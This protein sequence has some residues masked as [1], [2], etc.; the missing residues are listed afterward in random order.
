MTTTLQ[1]PRSRA[2]PG[3]QD[4]GRGIVTFALYAPGKR[5]VHLVGSFNDW[6]A[7]ADAMEDRGGG[8]WVT[9]KQLPRGKCQYQFIL[10]DGLVICD[11][12]AQEIERLAGPDAPP[13]AVI[14]VS[15]PI[16]QWQHDGWQ[17]PQL[18]DLIIQ[19][20]HV[21]DF[22]PQGTL[23]GVHSRL[24]YLREMGI[25]AIEFMPLYECS[26]N[27]YWGYEPAYFL[28]LRR[29]FGMFE[30]LL[31][32]V[33]EAHARGIAVILDLVLAHTGR[34]HPFHAMY[35]YEQSPWY[36][37]SVGE[38]DQYGLPM[39]DFRK[40]ATNSFVR[41]VQSYWLNVFHFDG[42][43]YDYLAGIG[44][45]WQGRGLPYLMRTAR[46]IRPEAY[47]IGECIPERPDLVNNSGIGCVWH[48]RTKL[49]LEALL[50]EGKSNCGDWNDFAT[51]VRAFDPATQDYMDATFMVNYLECHDDP[52]AV[53]EIQEAGFDRSVAMRKSALAA[54]IL[55]TLPGEPMLYQGQE[56]GED[57]VKSLQINKIHWE[58][59]DDEDG[60]SL[61]EHYRRMCHLRRGRA[62]LRCQNFHY[63]LVDANRK[64]IVYHRRLGMADQVVVAAN[65][66][67]D[68]VK[69]A[70][71]FPD[72]GMWHEFFSRLVMDIDPPLDWTL[73][74]YSAVIFLS[75][76]S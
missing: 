26:T 9:H 30:D 35:P 42:F 73:P 66:S 65:F 58:R 55:M 4:H 17:R 11:P 29:S 53:L 14:D 62:S 15:R 12:Y 20:V 8:F 54:T 10:D 61:R 37:R 51:T 18:R 52:R 16:Y 2:L 45:D 64:C 67:R 70:I 33:D 43:R 39:L 6:D 47:L 7:S 76:V 72:A 69:L 31:T 19:E 3:A 63:A 36:G 40:D 28:A 75:G 5:C 60:H 68:S 24:D 27:D 23:G 41:D 38:Q 21:G 44:A 1:D 59:L 34:Q 22:T 49:A 48:T 46:D 57:A 71:P 74:P 50:C 25:N 32:L 13:R 56:W